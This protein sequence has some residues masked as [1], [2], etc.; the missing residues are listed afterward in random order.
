MPCIRVMTV[1]NLSH[2]LSVCSLSVCWLFAVRPSAA[3]R[4]YVFCVLS[5]RVFSVVLC[6]LSVCWLCTVRPCFICALSVCSCVPSFPFAAFVQ[7]ASVLS[8]CRLY[9]FWISNVCRLVC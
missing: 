7:S 6:L 3:F 1:W 2:V 4:L 9:V 5:A 8:D